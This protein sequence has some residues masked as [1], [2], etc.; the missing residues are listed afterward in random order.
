MPE[1]LGETLKN[2]TDVYETDW[3][4]LKI[5]SGEWVNQSNVSL[6]IF[7]SV[8]WSGWGKVS[9][10]RASTRILGCKFKGKE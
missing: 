4:D 6:S 8:A 1:E 2:L 7:V 10:A 3:G 5:F 9:A